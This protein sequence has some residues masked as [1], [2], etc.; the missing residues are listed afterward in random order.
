MESPSS[1]ELPKQY[2]AGI[3]GATGY[4]GLALVQLIQRHPQLEVG[5]LTSENNAGKHFDDV[6]AV[7][8]AIPLI[9][10]QESYTRAGEV[11]VVFL[12]L[13][14]GESLEAARRFAAEGVRVIDLSADFRLDTP[15]AYGVWYGHD[16]ADPAL[17]ARFVYGLCEINR[18]QMRGAQLIA[19]PG[20]Y[21]TSVNLGLYPLAR[22]GV[23]GERVVIDAKSGISGAGRS[24][25]LL[26]QFV[27][28]NENLTPYNLGYRHRHIAEMELVLNSAAQAGGQGGQAGRAHRFSFNPHLLPVNQGILST[29]YVS[30]GG[31]LSEVQ[32]RELY[33]QQYAGEPFIH[34]LPAG[35]QATL[36]HV[37]GTNRCAISITPGGPAQPQRAGLRDCGLYRQHHQG[38]KR[39]GA[40]VL[41]HCGGAG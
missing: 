10:L 14:H 34:L 19:N 20:C 39:P 9:P 23:L 40:A 7:P 1:T 33:A 11:D 21:P 28:S 15:E 5:W 36:R 4:T 27:E 29:M 12:C 37:T 38:G 16:H 30:V 3:A 6:H 18:E 32:V 2:K 8:W 31:G 24:A 41:Q 26:Y 17:L 25:K 35:Q 22:A 13:P